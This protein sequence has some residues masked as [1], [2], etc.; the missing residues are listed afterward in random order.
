VNDQSVARVA[1]SLGA[2]GGP[3]RWSHLPGG[4]RG[5]V[6]PSLLLVL[7][8]AL[9]RLVK[10]VVIVGF[11]CLAVWMVVRWFPELFSMGELGRVVTPDPVTT[12]AVP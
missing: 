3:A 7:W 6:Q 2:V 8:V 4:G 9:R 10:P 5:P 1:A 12:P 11:F